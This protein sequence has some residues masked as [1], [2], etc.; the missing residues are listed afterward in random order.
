MIKNID[1]RIIAESFHTGHEVDVVTIQKSD[2]EQLKEQAERVWELKENKK[3]LGDLIE[4][5]AK[6][7]WVIEQQ[8]KRYR[9]AL[10]F[11]ANEENYFFD[12]KEYKIGLGVPESEIVIDYGE[13]ARKALEGESE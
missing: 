10:E 12:E 7:A 4:K 5:T 11:Y 3:A 8:N 13:K 6:I 2:Y 1:E 9:E